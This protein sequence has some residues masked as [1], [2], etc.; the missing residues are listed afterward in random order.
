MLNNKRKDRRRKSELL[1]NYNPGKVDDIED[2][3]K[4]ERKVH[5]SPSVKVKL[6][7]SNEEED[8]PDRAKKVKF[9]KLKS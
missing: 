1:V 4:V 6:F 8:S 9:V 5:F 3:S 2:E 7:K